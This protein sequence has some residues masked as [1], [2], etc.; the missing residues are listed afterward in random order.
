MRIRRVVLA[1]TVTMLLLTPLAGAQST[2]GTI[3]GHVTDGQG[4]ALPG[5]TVA[6]SSPNLQGVRTAITSEI[7]D[8]AISLLPS[9]NYSVTFELAGFQKQE[10][11][12]VLAPTQTMPLDVAL[13]HAVLTEE[14]TVVGTPAQVVTQTAQ[15]TT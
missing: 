6:V 1:M 8:Y 14:V 4:L 10:M 11:K 12:A 7:G 15:V 5:V 2:T 3:F 13:G 9:G